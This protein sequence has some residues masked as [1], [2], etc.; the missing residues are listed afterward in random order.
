MF[1][2]VMACV[3]PNGTTTKTVNAASTTTNGA[4]QKISTVGLGG[5]DVF[6]E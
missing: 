6:F 1:M 2:S 5:H 4:T 3:G